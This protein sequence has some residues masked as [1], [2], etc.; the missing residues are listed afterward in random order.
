LLPQGGGGDAFMPTTGGPSSADAVTV[1]TV[2]LLLLF[3]VPSRLVV[4]ALGGAGSPAQLFGVGA[5]LLWAVFQ[6]SGR[7]TLAPPRQPV[8]NAMLLFAAATLASYVAATVRP[9][10]DLELRAADR[11]LLSLMAW[12]GIVF[13]ACDGIAT[14][15]RLEVL[16]RRLVLAGGAIALL[17]ILQF[18]TGLSFVNYIHVPGLSVNSTVTDMVS[19]REGFS[20]PSGT[21]VHPIEYGIVLT[22]IL[23]VAL[24]FAIH[25][26]HRPR[27]RRWWPVGAIGV[28]VPISIS[29]SAIVCSIVVLA[30]LVPTW[31]R[32]LRR[33][34]YLAVAALLCGIFVVVPGMLGTLVGLFSGI[35]SD[36]SAQSRTGSYALAWEFISHKPVLGRGFQ[37]FLPEYRILDNQLLLSTIET[38][39]LGFLALLMLFASGIVAA[40][41][42]RKLSSDEP[43][44]QLAQALLASLAAG[45][46]SFALFDALS[47]PQVANL[48]M[49]MLGVAGALYRL[50]RAG[51]LPGSPDSED[52][53]GS[54]RHPTVGAGQLG[55]P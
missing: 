12:M 5:L 40:R 8:R 34:A 55:R 45:L 51:N 50:Q 46:A 4:G 2:S 7:L 44:R 17:G 29:R 19:N 28:T 54:G 1:L 15:A 6:V 9:I 38:G 24:H 37:T 36:T 35:G 43:G 26:K 16:L 20:R 30:V 31:S 13:V 27:L 52:A 39:F 53:P 48:V 10:D 42:A 14:R 25:D 3:A 41:R 23:P 21:A 11:G 47:F 49:L 18:E 33:R 32:R 22:M